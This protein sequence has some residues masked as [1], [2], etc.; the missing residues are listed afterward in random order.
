M[1]FNVIFSFKLPTDT[2]YGYDYAW[3]LALIYLWKHIVYNSKSSALSFKILTPLWSSTNMVPLSS[4]KLFW[5]REAGE[6]APFYC[7]FLSHRLQFSYTVKYV[8][9]IPALEL[10]VFLS[11]CERVR[12]SSNN[13]TSDMM[14][15]LHSLPF[16][17]YLHQLFPSAPLQLCLQLSFRPFLSLV[18]ADCY[19]V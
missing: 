19:L 11:S 12:T 1:Y 15:I 5:F 17:Y 16:H 14:L 6:L 7:T 3:L 4:A 18:S 13:N 8:F 10:T 2:H 9:P